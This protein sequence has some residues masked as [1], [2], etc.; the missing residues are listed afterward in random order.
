MFII[1]AVDCFLS[2]FRTFAN[3]KN[4]H[5]FPMPRMME[6]FWLFNSCAGSVF[7]IYHVVYLSPEFCGVR[8]VMRHLVKKK[9]F[10][11]INFVLL[12]IVVYV[13]YLMSN[14]LEI[15]GATIS[16]TFFIA[17]KFLTVILVFLLN[18][19]PR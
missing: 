1:W 11:K 2:E 3:C 19:L 6:C 5:L 12:A 17:D 9:I 15:W 16:Y 7:V 14:N 13:I 18:F 8:V 4:F 10:Y